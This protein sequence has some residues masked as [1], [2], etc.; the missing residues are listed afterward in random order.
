MVLAESHEKPLHRMRGKHLP[1]RALNDRRMAGILLQ[2]IKMH[3]M[4]A[5]AIEEK[6]DQLLEYLADGLSFAAFTQTRES[7]GHLLQPAPVTQKPSHQAQSSTAAQGV[8][9][10]LN[11][12][13]NRLAFNFSCD[14]L[15][16]LH[17]HPLGWFCDWVVIGLTP[18]T[19]H[20][21]PNF[22]WVFYEKLLSLG[23]S[24]ES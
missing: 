2:M 3:Q 6:A 21:P 23:S 7:A 17:S 18:F 19:Y 11:R 15:A 1:G 13:D 24:K 5:A 14:I 16:H 12:I 8:L 4:P 20:N 9:G 10:G 22:G